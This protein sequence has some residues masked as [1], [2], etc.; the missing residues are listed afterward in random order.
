MRI[1][2]KTEY[3]NTRTK[4]FMDMLPLYVDAL[5]FVFALSDLLDSGWNYETWANRGTTM[6]HPFGRFMGSYKSLAA[7]Y[8]S[9]IGLG[10]IARP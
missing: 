4:F 2:K 7:D 3:N 8:M 6:S 5:E 10:E 1:V 9:K